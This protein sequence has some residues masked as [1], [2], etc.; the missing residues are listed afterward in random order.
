MERI[1]SYIAVANRE[2]LNQVSPVEV[3]DL[4]NIIGGAVMSNADCETASGSPCVRGCTE[5]GGKWYRTVPLSGVKVCQKPGSGS[6]TYNTAQCGNA[7]KYSTQ[8]DCDGDSNGSSI[9]S[10][11]GPVC[12]LPPVLRPDTNSYEIYAE[13]MLADYVMAQK[14]SVNNTD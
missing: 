7:K 11:S 1:D 13:E 3:E 8:G 12:F 2:N 4:K 5:S 10:V 14:T 9:S 6:C